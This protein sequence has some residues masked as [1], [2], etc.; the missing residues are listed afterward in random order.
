MR[1]AIALPFVLLCSSA[2]A[3]QP[4]QQVADDQAT[5]GLIFFTLIAALA[6]ATG[7]HMLFLS[8][9]SSRAAMKKVIKD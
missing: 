2:L 6:V 9:R 3:Q 1:A 4:G 8:R 5:P 7:A